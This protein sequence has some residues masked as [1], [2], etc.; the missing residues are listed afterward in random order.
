MIAIHTINNSGSLKDKF[1]L[2]V[3]KNY[4]LHNEI[5]VESRI[6]Q[7]NLSATVQS[8]KIIF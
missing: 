3:Y 4:S 8:N 2:K 6:L 7:Q 5:D 1:F